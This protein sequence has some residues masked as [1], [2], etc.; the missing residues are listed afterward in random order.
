MGSK[1]KKPPAEKP[2]IKNDDVDDK[3]YDELSN[4]E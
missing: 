2:E 4:V 3:P 1:K